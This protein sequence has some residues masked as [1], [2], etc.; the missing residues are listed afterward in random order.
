[1]KLEEIIEG[2][3]EKFD[4]E[5]L[6]NTLISLKKRFQATGISVDNISVALIAL[7]MEV[8]KLEK[9]K[10]S[11]R[12]QLIISILGNF[13]EDICP[14]EDTPQEMILKQMVPTLIDNINEMKLPT[15]CF[16]CL[17]S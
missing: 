8:N 11:E 3:Y 5:K 17:K 4:T 10:Q 12:K 2:Y 7:M 13:I 16:S 9:L 1:M 15:G 6:L 14:G